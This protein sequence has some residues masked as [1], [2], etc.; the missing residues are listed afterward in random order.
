[1]RWQKGRIDNFYF[2]D[3]DTP[4]SLCTATNGVI[5]FASRKRCGFFNGREF[6]FLPQSGNGCAQIAAAR[7]G[8]VWTVCGQSLLRLQENGK[9][10]TVADLSWLGGAAQVTVLHE[11][12]EDNLW[13]G[14]QGAGLLRFREGKFERVATSFPLLYC[15]YEDRS[16]NLWLGTHGGGLDRLNRR[17]IFMHAAPVDRSPTAEGRVIPASAQCS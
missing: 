8:G 5:W 13:I 7:A 12:R 9:V 1:M 14:S 16:G 6:Q 2:G 10:E 11:D 17:Q 4:I 15:I 3:W